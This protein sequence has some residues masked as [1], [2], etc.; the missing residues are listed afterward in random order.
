[1]DTKVITRDIIALIV[2]LGAIATLF[3][4]VSDAGGQL[5]RTLAGL[6]VGYYFGIK[7]LPIAGAL[8]KRLG[9]K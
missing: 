9:K 1:M 4:A 6:I 7:E 3:F 8:G 5:V 2:V